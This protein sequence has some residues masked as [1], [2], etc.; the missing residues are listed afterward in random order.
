MMMSREPTGAMNRHLY[1]NSGAWLNAGSQQVSGRLQKVCHRLDCWF[2]DGSANGWTYR[3]TE[4][5]ME[6]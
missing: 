5:I 4:K 2:A 6:E 3:S 1:E